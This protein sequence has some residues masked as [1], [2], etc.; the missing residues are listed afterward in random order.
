MFGS[1]GQ[2]NSGG[3]SLNYSTYKGTITGTG[4]RIGGIVGT[5]N[6][7]PY[8]HHITL[9]GDDV[10]I[11]TS[12]TSDGV[13]GAV[14][15]GYSIRLEYI[16]I[17]NVDVPGRDSVG[18]IMGALD[19]WG[20][21]F[22]HCTYQGGTITG[23]NYV[24]G[25]VGSGGDRDERIIQ[26]CTTSGTITATGDRVGGIMGSANLDVFHC[27]SSM[28]ITASGNNVG[29]LVGYTNYGAIVISYS[30]FTGTVHGAINVGG[31][32]GALDRADASGGIKN[33]TVVTDEIHASGDT[34]GGLVGSCSHYYMKW[35]TFE[36]IINGVNNVGGLAG[37]FGYP[38]TQLKNCTV[39]GTI[40]AT[41]NKVAG[42]VG[43]IRYGASIENIYIDGTD[44]TISVSATSDYVGGIVGGDTDENYEQYLMNCHVDMDITG[45]DYVGGLV[46]MCKR[47]TFK[48]HNS[49]EGD[50][51]GRSYIGCV[52]GAWGYPSTWFKEFASTM[53]ASGTVTGTGSYIGGF[54]GGVYYGGYICDLDNTNITITATA[55]SDYVGG[56]IGCHPLSSMY[57]CWIFDCINKQNIT[58]RN[59]IG[60]IIGFM[61]TGKI[62]DCTSTGNITGTGYLGGVVGKLADGPNIEI[63]HCNVTANITGTEDIIGGIVGGTVLNAW[64]TAIKIEMCI[65]NGTIEGRDY[66]G[67]I[68]GQHNCWYDFTSMIRRSYSIGSVSG[69]NYVGG[70]AGS[71]RSIISCYSLANV[72][73]TDKVG[74]LIG[75][76]NDGVLIN[77]YA[78]G[79][80]TGSTNK[81]GLVGYKAGT[82]TQE[83]CFWDTEITTQSTSALGT[84][85]TTT[86]METQNTFTNWDFINTWNIAG[87]YPTLQNH[88]PVIQSGSRRSSSMS[89][90]NKG[91]SGWG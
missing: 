30:D 49:Y 56:I 23:R 29:G 31:I 59:Y 86:E 4:N 28:E 34:V 50:V 16:D 64:N 73:G 89:M 77:C 65:Y 33:C 79:I 81:G 15:W 74:G 46:G 19:A 27:S 51:S 22:D 13:G 41:G 70:V 37:D 87:G 10:T 32:A 14:G 17:I 25:I 3:G 72:T 43:R 71:T 53:T 40:N 5:V 67:G 24:G 39:K 1:W 36:G 78:A 44:L 68:L 48:G 84:G 91:Q 6:Q 9:D 66:V 85:K 83:D 26:Y 82:G 69:R 90:G 63:Y 61:H 55:T 20:F 76:F 45:R 88:F 62:A 35:S 80:V 57:E 12:A 21:L 75:N 7:K 54:I 60:G 38:Y 42:A 8:I 18:G 11:V 2:A 47:L 58:G 52:C